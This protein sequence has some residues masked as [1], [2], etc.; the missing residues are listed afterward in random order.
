MLTGS[1]K[2][3]HHF[4]YQ[5]TTVNS[6]MNRLLL[7]KSKISLCTYIPI[8]PTVNVKIEI[9]IQFNI[10]SMVTFNTQL[11]LLNLDWLSCYVCHRGRFFL[12]NK[13]RDYIK[14]KISL[15]CK[16]V[17]TILQFIQLTNSV[18]L[19]EFIAAS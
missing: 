10:C 15:F 1:L 17:W 6:Q 2:G 7:K 14:I 5:L 16:H 12:S 11:L 8:F 9:V 4:T 19:V 3:L 13:E 18:S